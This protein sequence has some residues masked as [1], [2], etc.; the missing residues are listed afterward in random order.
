MIA[1]MKI[2]R[3]ENGMHFSITCFVLQKEHVPLF[4]TRLCDHILDLDV[5]KYFRPLIKSDI[6]KYMGR[7][8][9][10]ERQKN[11]DG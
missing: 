5:E 9:F 11:S 7:G 10:Y 1:F 6:S 2:D 3:L 4:L 8:T